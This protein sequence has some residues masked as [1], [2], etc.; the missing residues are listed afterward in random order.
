WQF[1]QGLMELE[2]W[3][4]PKNSP[5]AETALR[6]IS[7]SL[8]REQQAAFVNAIAY[9]PTNLDALSLVSQKIIPVLPSSDA[10]LPKQVV[11]NAEWWAE[12]E[13]RISALW[14]EWKQKK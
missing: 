12:N 8:D 7:K 3:A 9:G 6:F 2:F 11:V 1:N 4:I 13:S 14:E 5:N 10:V